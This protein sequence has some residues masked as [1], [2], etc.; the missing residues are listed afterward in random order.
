MSPGAGRVRRDPTARTRA[1]AGT[2]RGFAGWKAW[3]PPSAPG[4]ALLLHL[5]V[6]AQHL[7]VLARERPGGGRPAGQRAPVRHINGA[8]GLDRDPRGEEQL[9]R[10]DYRPL[11]VA[12]DLHDPPGRTL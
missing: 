6:E 5:R 3:R 8:V 7:S 2:S 11:A 4:A 12:S 9:A 10:P 1:L